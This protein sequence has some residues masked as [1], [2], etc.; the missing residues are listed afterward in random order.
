MT[1]RPL[2]PPC[3]P[4]GTR[5]FPNFLSLANNS[6]SFR[7]RLTTDTLAF[8]YIFPATGQI[9]EFHRFHARSASAQ[10]LHLIRQLTSS[11]F[12]SAGI[13][14]FRSFRNCSKFSSLQLTPGAVIFISSQEN[15]QRSAFHRHIQ[16]YIPRY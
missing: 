15:P 6:P 13:S 1:S 7:F 9:L 3:V 16:A 12:S 10:P 11:R 4:F 2:T 14:S 5:R 8:G